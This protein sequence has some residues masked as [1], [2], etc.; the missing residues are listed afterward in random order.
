MGKGLFTAVSIVFFV[1]LK[2]VRPDDAIENV[3]IEQN[4]L[5]KG[6]GIS[7]Q[8]L[9]GVFQSFGNKCLL[10]LDGLDEHAHGEHDNNLTFNEDVLKIIKK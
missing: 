8:K 5:L 10:I 6:S 3:I 1:F 4:P 7:Q 9:N 2:L